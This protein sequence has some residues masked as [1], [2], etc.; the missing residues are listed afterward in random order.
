MSG[1][2]RPSVG[3][4]DPSRSASAA[5]GFSSA[6]STARDAFEVDDDQVNNDDEDG[7]GNRI[8]DSDDELSEIEGWDLD[9]T[10][11]SQISSSSASVSVAALDLPDEEQ[12]GLG[13]ATS[14]SSSPPEDLRFVAASDPATAG[15][16]LELHGESIRRV[17]TPPLSGDEEGV[18]MVDTPA[19]V[20]AISSGLGVEADTLGRERRAGQDLSGLGNDRWQGIGGQEFS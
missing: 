12:T 18:V 6:G 13:T 16:E 7:A 9:S 2:S 4:R 11:A 15:R 1:P 8:D 19:A 3:R 20:V 14:T 10:D 17:G 5:T